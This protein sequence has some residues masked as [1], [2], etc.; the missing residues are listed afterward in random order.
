MRYRIQPARSVMSE[1]GWTTRKLAAEMRVDETHLR[2]VLKGLARPCD[3][4]RERLPF[5]LKRPLEELL[6]PDV[7]AKAYAPHNGRPR[8]WPVSV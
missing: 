8:Q 6:H 5:F 1:Q 4:V 7:L 2:N 3:A